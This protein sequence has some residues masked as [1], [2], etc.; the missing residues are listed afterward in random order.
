MWILPLAQALRA[1]PLTGDER[2][3]LVTV[4]FVAEAIAALIGTTGSLS[5]DCYHITGGQE[6]A[7]SCRDILEVLNQKDGAWEGFSFVN[8][9]TWE[10]MK[11][12][13]RTRRRLMSAI[14][15]YVPFIKTDAVYANQRLQRELGSDMPHC[16]RFTEYCEEFAERITLSEA[17]RE[18]AVP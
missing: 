4:N 2:L 3:D 9:V 6:T 14:D 5:H 13:K 18:S 12:R 17:V 15:Y 16:P 8:Q 7:V 11:T 10:E 1:L